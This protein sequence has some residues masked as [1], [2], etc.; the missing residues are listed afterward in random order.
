[1]LQS[2]IDKVF[3]TYN[4]KVLKEFGEN[5]PLIN[6]KDEEFK[7]LSDDELKAKF[8]EWKTELTKDPS[9][10]DEK[11]IEIFAAIKNASRR[12]LGKSFEVRGTD[13]EWKMVYYDVQLIGGMVLNAGNVS[14]M[15]TGE[16]K[17][18]VCTLPVILNALTGKGVHLVTVNDYLAQRDAEWMTPLYEFCGL[19]VGT[20]VHGKNHDERKAAY[21][22]DITYGTNNEFGF[23]YLRDNMAQSIEKQVQRPLHFA[24]VDE[25]DSI[26]I[27]EARTPLIIS[28][29]GDESTEKYGIHAQIIPQLK[30]TAHYKVDPKSKQVTLTE[31]GI[32]KVESLLGIDNVFTEAGFDEVHHIEN[33]LKAHAIM[34]KDQ[35]YVV[36]DGQVV[37]IDEFTGRMMAG[38]RFSDGLHQ[39]LE[40]KEN[41]EI[42]RESKTLATITFQN[43]FRLYEKLSGMAGTAE[44]EAE[45][46]AKI[47]K[48]DTIVIPTNNTLQR[49][50]LPDKIFKNEIGKFKALAVEVKKINERGQPVLIG[51]INIDK[52]EALS[53]L[54]T[55]HHIKHEVLNAKQHA[56]EAEIVANAG[57]KGAVTIATNMAGRGT[58]IKLGE[59]VRELGGLIIL[60]TE[61]HESRRIDNQLRGRSGRQGDPGLS[62]FYVSMT[63]DLM[64]RFGGEKMAAMMER[65]GLPDEEAIEN[66]M[67]SNSVESAQ[68]KIEGFHFDSRKHVVQYD[69]VMNIHRTKI[70]AR[71]QK[72]L[73]SELV[74]E[75]IEEMMKDLVAQIVE[76]NAHSQEFDAHWDLVEIHA[77]INQ[78][79]KP[80]NEAISLTELES[81]HHRDELTES[82][83]NYILSAWDE[84]KKEYPDDKIDEIAKQITLRSIDELWLKHI[85]EM[86]HLRDRVALAGYAQ[87]DPIMEYKS[88]GFKLFSQL[89][90]DIRHTAV[91]N[92]FRIEFA[93][94]LTFQTNNYENATTNSDQINATLEDTGE[95]DVK[96]NAKVYE[97]DKPGHS[98]VAEKLGKKYENIGRNDICPCGSGKKF[99]KCH[100][101]NL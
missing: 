94:N 67:I 56:R 22:A 39:A 92:L 16:G 99:K 83:Q 65:L 5:V 98:V 47:Y 68:K 35:D 62:Q 6:A 88:Q 75:D 52:S 8:A 30:E 87:K 70:Y 21:N 100:G 55:S 23:D 91:S 53:H 101:K 85:D 48:L 77:S 13:E 73:G 34:I 76:Q 9:K 7:K 79:H 26:L 82:L 74:L 64:R 10:V 19:T 69:D 2:L 80:D 14:E 84:K 93:Q 25:V 42:Q 60:G 61:R 66:R 81:F 12:L 89:L 43:Y 38:R 11:L 18:F 36:R 31:D 33:A 59:G 97:S 63:D 15:K 90:Q 46:F 78:I 71:R 44:T 72:L 50:D 57:Q 29:A 86:T 28:A 20:I 45:E 96:P 27:D 95:F 32:E 49:A 37:I 40:A 54:L 51:T 17:T 1:M 58:D 41:V 24:I 3:G 4:E